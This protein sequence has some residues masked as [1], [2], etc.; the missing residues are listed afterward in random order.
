VKFH[1]VDRPDNGR[2]VHVRDNKEFISKNVCNHQWMVGNHRYSRL[3]NWESLW[4][5][6][7]LWWISFTE[8]CGDCMQKQLCIGACRIMHDL[9]EI[10]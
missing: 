3:C 4:S 10:A 1:A 7:A 2:R 9:A 6:S 8:W 5:L